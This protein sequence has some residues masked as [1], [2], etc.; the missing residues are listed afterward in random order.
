VLVA[1]GTAA[2]GTWSASP[3]RSTIAASHVGAANEAAA[4]TDAASLL[5]A[6]SLPAGATRSPVEPAGD[7]SVLAQPGSGPPLT[8]NVVD[9]SAWWLLADAPAAVL[10]YVQAHPP[11]GSRRV[12][13]ST[14]STGTNG[15]NVEVVAF[16]RPPVAGVL[17]TRW[18]VVEVVRLA[19]GSTGLRADAQV[20]WVTPRPASE[21]IPPGAHLVRVSVDSSIAVNRP[22]QRPF[23]VTV[24]RTLRRI[25]ALLNALPAAQP[26]PRSCPVDFGISVR[27]AFYA[28]RRMRPLA[29]AVLD[30]GGCG[31][32]QLT[33]GGRPQPSLEGDGL[34]G[35]GGSSIQRLDSILG[36]KLDTGFS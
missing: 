17:D 33:I 29:V 2:L 16:A 32:V 14:G 6:L 10:A 23:T 28:K 31:G 3:S 8:P 7:G 12:L 27:L 22:R 5:G 25:V 20:V 13:A 21:Q 18:L 35:P 34:S 19:G 30:A 15:T 9:E 1:S 24:P 36:F 11:A 26:G 4:R